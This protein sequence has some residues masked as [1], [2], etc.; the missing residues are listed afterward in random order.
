[1]SSRTTGVI[2]KPDSASQSQSALYQ[3]EI[4]DSE[5]KSIRGQLKAKTLKEALRK[6]EKRSATVVSLEKVTRAPASKAAGIK[7]D[8]LL[9]IF[10]ELSVLI[11]CGIPLIRALTV[12]IDQEKDSAVKDL[13]SSMMVSIEKGESFSSAMSRFPETFSRFHTSLI[14]A[15]ET[16]GFTGRSLAYLASVL[17]KESNLKKRVRA[18]LNYPLVVFILGMAISLGA[19]FMIYPYVKMV[20]RDLGVSLPLYSRA[21]MAVIDWL[22]SPY[23][24][25]PLVFAAFYVMIKLKSILS[26]TVHGRMWKEKVSLSIPCLRDI[27]KKTILTRILFV[28]EALLA[29]GVNLI[30]AL[31]L[32]ADCCENL[33]VEHA[34]KSVVSKIKDGESMA[35]GME[36]Y[37][38][39]FPRTVISMISVGEQS[40][41][42]AE[43]FRKTAQLYTMELTATLESFVKLVEPVAIISM[44]TVITVMILSFFVPIYMALS[45]F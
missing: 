13:L 28:M 22:E 16:G 30:N 25:I 15:G 33:I 26:S 40:G 41:D 44:G 24:S 2:S 1:M 6:L 23:I 38:S 5:G 18:S 27:V 32:A 39:L 7:G 29:S 20:V 3:Y 12:M 21:M 14:K 36:S 17:E 8:E 19:F 34:L 4:K 10:R 45:R 11:E 43:L 9:F 31:E 35:Q 42:L 37:P